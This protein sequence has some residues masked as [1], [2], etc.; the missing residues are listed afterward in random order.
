M[1]ADRIGE[2]VRLVDVGAR[3]GIDG[4]WAPFYPFLD[5]LGFEPDSAECERLTRAASNLP[6]RSRFLPIALGDGE[7]E[8]M[9]NVCRWSVA[10]SVY[11][12]NAEVLEDFPAAAGL[13]DVAERRSLATVRLDN[14]CA[15]EQFTPDC[16]KLD[17]EGAELAVLRG[18]EA[19]L[20]GS[21]VLD[22]EAE[23]Q[24]LFRGQPL[25]ADVDVYLRERGWRLLGLRRI[26]WRRTAG[27]SRIGSG[28]GG[29]L[30]SADALYLND[31]ALKRGLTIKQTLKLVLI[32]SAYRQHDFTLA[33][34]RRPPLSDLPAQER[35]ALEAGLAPPPSWLH[36]L[37]GL[38]LHGL[39]SQHRRRLADALQ[40]GTA[41]IWQDA[42]HF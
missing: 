28:Y 23:F 35:R 29:Q 17:V 38:A 22:V 6:Y 20:G 30:V 11:E 40:D 18:A 15:R 12:P 9:F 2:P 10:S 39:D 5:V 33:L 3:G 21:L 34:L 31:H 25:F 4:R 19:I 14:V 42:H 8:V 41:A 1:L 7:H 36:R 26:C 16:L 27:L 13:M 37:A 24:E 32:L